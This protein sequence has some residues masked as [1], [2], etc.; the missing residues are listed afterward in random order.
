MVRAGAG[1]ADELLREPHVEQVEMRG[2]PMAGWLQVD[3]AALGAEGTL[4]R[5]VD[6]GATF[7]ASLP[8]KS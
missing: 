5:W 3:A 7:V 6:V 2:R 1:Q 4:E 8:P